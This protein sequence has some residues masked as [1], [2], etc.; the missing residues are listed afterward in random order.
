MPLANSKN[1]KINQQKNRMTLHIGRLFA[2]AFIALPLVFTSC[3]TAV[4]KTD[5]VGKVMLSLHSDIVVRSA[6]TIAEVD[7][8]NFRFV[9]V[10]SYGSS[11]YYR[12]GDVQ[13]P[14][15]WY[16]GVFKLQAESCTTEEAHAGYGKLRYEGISDAFSVT[17]G[18]VA[19]ASVVCHVA[20]VSVNV[21]FDDSMYE[22]FAATKLRVE[23]VEPVLD[24]DGNI[25]WNEE[26]VS[27]RTLDLDAINQ[28]GFYNLS[29]DCTLLRYTLFLKTD[30]AEEF[31]ESKIGYFVGNDG[32][33]ALLR[34]GDVITLRVKYVGAPIV[35]SGIKF[36]VSGDRVSVN[37]NVSLDH[38]N[39]DTVVE[40]E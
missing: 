32:A 33:P 13:W 9:G 25:D 12:Y 20:N 17:Q 27:T 29:S 7:D 21:L 28:S 22:A 8:F 19:T 23:T 31:V 26:P 2:L 40:D 6:V 14:M 11:E 38:Y 39:K 3:D 4:E 35:T 18:N 5:G 34:G 1:K 37:N 15:D 36:I 10:G 30:G 16:F 24:E